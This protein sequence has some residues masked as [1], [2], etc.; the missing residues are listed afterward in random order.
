MYPLLRDFSWF[1]STRR[2]EPPHVSNSRATALL[3][4]EGKHRLRQSSISTAVNGGTYNSATPARSFSHSLYTPRLGDVTT[5][6]RHVD[7]DGGVPSAM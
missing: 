1:L 2:A 7:G 5:S 4:M 6:V 3:L